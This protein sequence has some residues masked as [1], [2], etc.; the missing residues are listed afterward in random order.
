MFL[1]C[2]DEMV[3]MNPSSTAFRQEKWTEHKEAQPKRLEMDI[4][5]QSIKLIES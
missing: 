2:V 4:D 5:V 3:Q 1:I